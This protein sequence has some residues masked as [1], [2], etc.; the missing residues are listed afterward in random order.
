M[1]SGSNGAKGSKRQGLRQN[2]TK[3]SIRRSSAKRD[4]AYVSPF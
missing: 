4:A 2:M 1:A 3:A